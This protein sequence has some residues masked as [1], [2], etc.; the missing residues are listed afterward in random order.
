M[1]DYVKKV[2]NPV[3]YHGHEK[4]A[5]FFEGWYFKFVDPTERYAFA[6]IPGIS[7]D[8]NG[9]KHGTKVVLYIAGN[10]IIDL[11]K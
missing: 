1:F 5:P 4:K 9:K 3:W 8:K 11:L 7:F 6:V 2:M 10:K